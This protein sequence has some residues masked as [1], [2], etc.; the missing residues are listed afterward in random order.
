MPGPGSWLL[1]VELI[2]GPHEPNLEWLQAWCARRFWRTAAVFHDAIPL[3]WG[4]AAAEFYATYMGGLGSAGC[5]FT[6]PSSL[7]SL[8]HALIVLWDQPK[9]IIRLQRELKEFFV[10]LE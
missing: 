2:S 6:S 7:W 3:G 8:V 1:L 10:A 4:G 9:M 5:W